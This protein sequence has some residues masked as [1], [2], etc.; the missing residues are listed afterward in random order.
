MSVACSISPIKVRISPHRPKP[1]SNVVRSSKAE[2]PLRR[3]SVPTPPAPQSIS[4]AP[5]PSPPQSG[6][7][8][9][10]PKDGV[11]TLEYQRRMAKEMQDLLPLL[12][13]Y[14]YISKAF[15]IFSRLPCTWAMFGFAVGLLTEYATGADFVQQLR[16]LLSNF[17]IVDLD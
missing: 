8:A 4:A 9:T 14:Q 16:I 17:G 13:R 10:A 2:G 5:P 12:L 11:V 1:Y 3:P 6:V 15:N 7:A